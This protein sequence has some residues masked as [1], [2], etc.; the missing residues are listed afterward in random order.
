MIY[1]G[2][3]VHDEGHTIGPLLWKIRE[4]LK[5]RGRDFRV[6]VLDDA[7]EDA[8]SGRLEAYRQVLPL[9]VLRNGSC[10]GYGACLERLA[11]EALRR[12]EYP[13]RDALV[14]LQADMTDS[15]DAIP[16]MVRRFEGGMDLVTAV[17]AAEPAPPRRVALARLGA[18]LLARSLPRPQEVTD[19]FGS[20]RLYRLFTLQRAVQALGEGERLISHEGWAANAEL[21]L[22]VWPHVRRAEEV[23]AP[24][25]YHRRYRA[26]RFRAVRT[27]R[28]LRQLARAPGRRETERVV[29]PT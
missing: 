14:T 29:A 17:P 7:S 21:L 25:D 8:A 12:S 26:S 28:D 24:V 27:V 13:R 11:R 6:L 22:R 3:P 9:T 5:G 18:R 16:E 1:I 4:L 20:L 15:P 10:R 2:I 23:M 19:P